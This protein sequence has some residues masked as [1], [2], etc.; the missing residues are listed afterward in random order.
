MADCMLSMKKCK[1]NLITDAKANCHNDE[2]DQMHIPHVRFSTSQQFASSL[3]LIHDEY[4]YSHDKKQQTGSFMVGFDSD[5]FIK[6]CD[7]ASPDYDSNFVDFNEIARELFQTE[8]AWVSRNLLVEAMELLSKYH[9]FTICI[10]KETVMC[11]RKGKNKTSRAY[12]N[13]PLKADCTFHF[14]LA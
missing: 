5:K 14:K 6:C 1:N 8:E 7:K 4:T 12:V 10:E 13:G 2:C 3:K 9:G 11:N